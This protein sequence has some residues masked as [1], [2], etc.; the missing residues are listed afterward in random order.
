LLTDADNRAGLTPT[1]TF[2]SSSVP[3]AVSVGDVWKKPGVL[4]GESNLEAVW[5]GSAWRNQSSIPTGAVIDFL[6]VLET[7]AEV[8]QGFL[9]PY[10][11][12]VVRADYPGLFAVLR[13]QYGVGDGSTTFNLP[14]LRGR[15][16]AGLDNMGG[17]TAS[18]LSSVLASTTL[19][20]AGGSQALASHNH[21]ITNQG[22][23][24]HGSDI[25]GGTTW[26]SANSGQGYYFT[27]A[28]GADV[29]IY[30]TGV[31][32][33]STISGVTDATGGGAQGNVQPTMVA[34]KLLKT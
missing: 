17:V 9:L 16:I 8:P 33:A 26:L 29:N 12:Q 32:V 19:G 20:T 30:Y 18:R 31:T 22:S 5:D 14:D 21:T 4:K 24:T 6:G 34:W 13:T 23:H 11:Q 25:G 10:G 28:G 3:T 15:V 7:I 27:A 2:M 1:R